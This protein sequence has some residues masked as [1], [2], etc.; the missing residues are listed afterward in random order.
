[1]YI[2]KDGSG[3]LPYPSGSPPI[4]DL[5][6][7]P[8][9]NFRLDW[10]TYTNLKKLYNQVEHLPGCRSIFLS[11]LENKL[12]NLGSPPN[13]LMMRKLHSNASLAFY[14]LLKIGSNDAIIRALQTKM[15]ENMYL[16]RY[17]DSC[18]GE[19]ADFEAYRCRDDIEGLFTD[20]LVFMHMEPTDFDESLLDLLTEIIHYNYSRSLSIK[21]E[22][23]DKILTLKYNRLRTQLEAA[24]EELNVHKEQ[25]IE[26]ISR[27]GFPQEMEKYLLEID[28]LPELSNYQSVNSGLIGNLRSFFEALVKNIAEKIFAKTGKEYPKISGRQEIGNKRAYIKEHLTL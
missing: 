26:M 21:G 2:K 12:S 27:Y 6:L 10:D 4:M 23:E 25:I 16:E 22:F 7:K 28:K 15:K 24:N 13:G 9:D 3:P 14:F 11:I 1:M 19:S 17:T 18:S 20:V 8:S 5:E